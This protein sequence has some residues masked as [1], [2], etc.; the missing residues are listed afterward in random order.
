MKAFPSAL[1]RCW[2]WKEC[3]LH[4][5]LST[6]KE[7]TEEVPQ[8]RSPVWLDQ[9][10]RNLSKWAIVFPLPIPRGWLW[11]IKDIIDTIISEVQVIPGSPLHVLPQHLLQVIHLSQNTQKL[12]QVTQILRDCLFYKLS[13]WKDAKQWGWFLLILL[14][15]F[16]QEETCGETPGL[17]FLMPDC[18]L[19]SHV[20]PLC[21]MG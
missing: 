21:I 1:A 10:Y 3:L 16:Q 5:R 6:A 15:H 14:W 19:T 13:N 11:S 17:N 7:R 2:Y 9:I 18:S 4:C 8:N 20:I 12:S